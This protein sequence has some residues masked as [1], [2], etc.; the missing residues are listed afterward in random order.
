M[1][2][3]VVPTSAA[4]ILARVADHVL[5]RW[6]SSGVVRTVT[7]IR[8][9]VDTN[10]YIQRFLY[11]FGVWEPNLTHWLRNTLRVGDVFIDVGAHIGYFS[12]LASG[13]VGASGRV[14]AIEPNP[15]AFDRMLTNLA[16][17]GFQNVE[18][19]RAA[20][21]TE[22][23]GRKSMHVPNMGNTGRATSLPTRRRSRSATYKFDAAATTLPQ[24]VGLETLQRAAVIKID[25]EGDELEV[26]KS[27]GSIAETV[28]PSCCFVIEVSPT[29]LS[30]RGSSSRDVLQLLGDA[31]YT[32]S[33][34]DNDYSPTSYPAAIRNPAAPAALDSVPLE[35]C[36]LVFTKS[37]R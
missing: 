15:Y 26:L 27:I 10:D 29:R 9:V 37:L 28:P 16:I 31:G 2:G 33:H 7:D 18:T 4:S 21:S 35:Q 14:V 36:D 34:L 6:P 5:R 13:L 1:S 3:R 25:V 11:C 24:V 12:L 8:I 20:V 17:N 19:I 22:V 30:R 32:A 23:S